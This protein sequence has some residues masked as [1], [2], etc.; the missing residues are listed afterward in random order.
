MIYE[1]I[2]EVNKQIEKNKKVIITIG[3]SFT[4]GH[5]SI[6]QKLWDNY[7]VEGESVSAGD[8]AFT[9]EQK[10]EILEEFPD[11]LDNTVQTKRLHFYV[12]EHNN[13]YGSILCNKY[14]QGDYTHINLG[15]RGNG[16]RS[17]IKD[18]YFCPDILWD[19]I[20]EIIVIYCPSAS[21]RYDFFNDACISYVNQQNTWVSVWPGGY[22]NEPPYDK[23]STPYDI[24]SYGINRSLYSYKS[25]VLEQIAHVQELLLWCKYKKVKKLIITPAFATGIY[26]KEQ[27]EHHLRTQVIRDAHSRELI[28]ETLPNKNDYIDQFTRK[29]IDRWVNYWPWDN[30]FRPSGKETFMELVQSQESSPLV[31]N[32]WFYRFMGKGTP[33]K[34]I[35]PCAHPSVKGHD[36]FAQYLYNHL[37]TL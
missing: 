20:E 25:C 3:D 10:K 28:S 17:S 29:Q 33:D 2:P 30:M 5:G 37:I 35:T 8:W 18:L 1:L 19:K 6:A 32:T 4:E 9:P 26:Q 11:I 23:N 12:H 22:R 21:E 34:W 15:R 13:S 7:Y 27:F 31:K 16:N 24:I 36:L 14:L